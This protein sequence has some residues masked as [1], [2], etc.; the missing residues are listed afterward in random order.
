MT[1]SPV[2]PRCQAITLALVAAA[3][4]PRDRRTP[5]DT[6]VVVIDGV[7]NV[8][9]PRFTISNFDSKVAKLIHPGLTSVDTPTM[10][11]RLELASRMQMIDPLTWE[12]ELR[13]DARF[14]DGA[15][16]LAT[17]V[18]YTYTSMLADG[19]ESVYHK[20][21]VER[22]TGVEAVG[23]RVVRFHLREPLA[24]FETDVDFGIISERGT[25]AG[26]YLLR[27]LTATH[28]L[29]SANPYYFGAPPKLPNLDIKFVKDA[30]A[31]LLMMVGGSADLIQ[32]GVRLD[33]LDEVAARPRVT[34]VSSPSALLT[35]VMLNNADAA[36]GD[37]RVRQAIAL[38]IDRPALIAAKLGGRAVLATGL[39]APSHYAYNADV[40][41]W[42]RDLARAKQLLDEAGLR[43]PDGD[44]PA[45][46]LHLTYK[47][48]ADAFRVSVARVIAAQLAE[49]G[50]DVEVR[51]FEF[52]TF[53]ADVKKGAYQIASMQTSE[54]GN[55]DFYFNYFNSSRIPSAANPD[56]GDRW[57]YKNPE[58]DRLTT[59][60]RHELDPVKRKAIYDEVQRIVATEVPIVPLWHEDNVVLTHHD[61][62]GY[63]ITPN[64]R[65]SGVQ[66]TTKA[67]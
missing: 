8:S 53:F 55:P 67:R 41:H 47:T 1:R 22:F 7:V 44:G 10:A 43:D 11:P 42:S 20:S 17:D 48:S 15:P 26:P 49:V 36:L 25:G 50:I 24:T 32:N 38:A 12:V 63:T 4:A 13:P 29:L 62:A 46:R 37:V 56:G 66:T 65:L 60:G 23:E 3:C 27:E 18:A 14:S 57:R 35:Y 16:V 45:P 9:D 2:H 40:P 21:F 28:A 31:R 39:L 64:A 54:I 59:A 52:A 34:L 6:L 5:D 61:V 19:S 58:V 51:P 33:L 30:S